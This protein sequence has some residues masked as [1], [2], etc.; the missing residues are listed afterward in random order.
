MQQSKC[1]A[2]PLGDSPINMTPSVPLRHF[3][4]EKR[5]IKGFEPLASRATIWRANQLRYTHHNYDLQSFSL[6]NFS[7]A[8]LEGFEPPTHGLEGRCSIQLSYRHIWDTANTAISKR[9]MGIEPTYP[10]WK[11]GVLPL[12]YTRM[13]IYEAGLPF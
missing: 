8:C 7:E 3:T 10:A 11:A 6:F 5:W 9:V 12:N 4:N 13:F 1:C 2:L